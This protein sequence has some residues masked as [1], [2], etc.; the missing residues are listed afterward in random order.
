[1]CK[2]FHVIASSVMVLFTFQSLYKNSIA[3]E[4]PWL[5]MYFLF[6][7][8]AIICI[9][10]FDVYL[11]YSVFTV[12]SLVAAG[13]YKVCVQ[14]H[15]YLSSTVIYCTWIAIML[16]AV[17]TYVMRYSMWCVCLVRDVVTCLIKMELHFRS[18]CDISSSHGTLGS[19]FMHP[20]TA[21]PHVWII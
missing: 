13:S 3:L 7:L 2:I 8:S 9:L 12:N 10:Q 6:R 5:V 17:F 1:M 18:L 14:C 16:F 21:V 19:F 4:H 15:V 11:Y 20:Y